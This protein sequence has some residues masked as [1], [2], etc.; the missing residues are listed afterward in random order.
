MELG[1]HTWK[2]GTGQVGAYASLPGEPE[3]GSSGVPA[4]DQDT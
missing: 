3:K 1:G 2:R 4:L